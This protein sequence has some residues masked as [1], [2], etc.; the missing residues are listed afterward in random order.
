M[1]IFQSTL[2]NSSPSCSRHPG[3]E[4]QILDDLDHQLT[5]ENHLALENHLA[6]WQRLFPKLTNT[7]KKET[8]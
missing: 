7:L 1:P 5:V 4:E 2:P 8:K 6:A 3:M